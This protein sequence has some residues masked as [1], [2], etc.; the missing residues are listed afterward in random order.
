MVAAVQLRAGVV[1]PVAAVGRILVVAVVSAYPSVKS[2]R[3]GPR[4]RPMVT[5]LVTRLSRVKRLESQRQGRSRRAGIGRDHHLPLKRH[6]VLLR[7][8]PD[9]AG[10]G[11]G[12]SD[13]VAAMM[14]ATSSSLGEPEI[15]MAEEGAAGS[16]DRSFIDST[17]RSVVF[18]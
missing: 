16:T 9:G 12:H 4:Q 15:F 3:S 1:E 8:Q 7:A 13:S 10:A 6:D 18:Y 11:F 17:F 14:A 5:N 2:A